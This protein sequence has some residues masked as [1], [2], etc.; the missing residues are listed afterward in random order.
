MPL[1]RAIDTLVI[2]LHDSNSAV[3][4]LLKDLAFGEF[5]CFMT[6]NCKENNS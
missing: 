1:T 4:R 3:G 6:W 5:E 2:T